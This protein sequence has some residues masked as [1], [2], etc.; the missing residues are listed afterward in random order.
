MFEKKKINRFLSAA[1][2]SVRAFP[3]FPATI[4]ATDRFA[5]RTTRIRAK[6]AEF[7]GK[8]TTTDV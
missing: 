7:A 8:L 3:D 2:T 5:S 6:T 1:N 4:V